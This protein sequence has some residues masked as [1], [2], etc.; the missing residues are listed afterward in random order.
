MF[1]LKMVVIAI[2]VIIA[3]AWFA[4]SVMVGQEWQKYPTLNRVATI[5]DVIIFLVCLAVICKYNLWC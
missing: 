1:T 3:I 5:G 2:A 4:F